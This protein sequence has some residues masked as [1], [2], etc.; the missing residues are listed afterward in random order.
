[1]WWREN[2]RAKLRLC[3]RVP[4]E[5]FLQGHLLTG[6]LQRE[7][8]SLPVP[9]HLAVKPPAQF[10]C[11]WSLGP[12]YGN[13]RFVALVI[14]VV[15]VLGIVIL[16]D[17][18]G[19]P[20]YAQTADSSLDYPENSTAAVAAFNA[21]DQDGDEIRW[22]LSGR[23]HALFIIDGGVLAFRES[24]NYEEPRSAIN[25]GQLSERNVY[26]VT[27]E[28]NGGTHDVVVT[29]TDVDDA[30]TASIDR[31]Q[32]QVS[33][34]LGAGLSDEDVGVS[35]QR[36]QWSRSENR[37]TWT[38]IEG[39]TSPRWSPTESDEG[40]YLRATVTYSDKFGSGKTA[41][42]VSAR[43]V[44]ART[45][46]NAA[47]SFVDRRGNEVTLVTLSVRENTAVGR[48]IGRRIPATDAD[49]DILFYELLDT[50]DLEDDD[51]DAR[52][53]IDSLSGQ[54]KVGKVLGADDGE[55]EDEATTLT[56][57]PALPENED[58]DDAGNSEYVLRVKVSDPS[59]A[60]ATVNVIV[61]VTNV[62]EPP[63]FIE[64]VPTLLR[65]KE[66]E[67]PPVITFGDNDSPVDAD[68]FAVTDQDGG[69]VTVRHRITGDDHE[70]LE[71]D[72]RVLT[73]KADHEPDFEMQ[74][75]YSI[76]ITA[77]S[78]G[79][80]VSLDVT[81]EVVDGEDLGEVSLSQR[82]PQVGIEVHATPSDPDGGMRIRRWEWERSDAITVDEDGNPSAECREDPDMPLNVVDPNSWTT[83]DEASTAAYTPE[84]ADVDRCLRAT[85]FYTDNFGDREERATEVFEA[86]VQSR[87]TANAAPT[88]VDQDLNSPGDQSVRT[89]RKIAEN[90]EAGQS[91]GSP[92]AAFDDDD[93]L[94]IYA[95][96]G[97]DAAFFSLSRND[98]QLKTKASLNFEAR[99]SYAVVVTAT[100]PSGASDSIQVTINVT[101][102][103]DPVHITG[104][105]SVS[106]VENGTDPV[107]SFTAF[108]EGEHVIRW[109][110]SGRDDGVFTI[111]DGVLAFKEPPNYEDPQSAST[112]AV[113]SSRNEYRVTVEAAGGTRNVTVTVTDVDEVGSV[114]ID[115]PQPQVGRLLSASLLDEDDGVEE[116]M[117]RWARSEDRRR[118][119]HIEGATSP[120]RLPA[121]ADEGMYLR[122][123]VTYTD[124]FGSGKT[125]RTVT[126]NPV[127]ARPPA[128]A[129]PSFSDQDD[130]EATRY[131]DV[132]RFVDEGNVKRMAIGEP[133]SA[134]DADEDILFYEFLDTPDL[135]DD[136][137]DARFTID[138]LS[139]QI[140]VGKV[141]GADPGE[142]EDEDS[143]TL[144]G[145]PALPTDE[146]AG[147]AGNSE[148]VLRVRASDP[149]TAT[150]I[151]NVIV[152]VT[153][154]NEAPAFGEDPPTL[155]SVVENVDP[156]V[157]RIGHGS[158]SI[159]AN[160][161][162][163]TDQ[164][165][166]VT[167]PDGYDDTTYAYSVSGAD[168][169]AF[170]FDD[171][172]VLGFSTGHSPD[173]EDQSSYSISIVAHSG[174][175]SRTLSTTLDVTVE[176]VDAEDAGAVF[177][178][179]RQP[180]VGVAVHATASDEDG[181]VTIRRWA[182]ERSDVVTVDDR[183]VPSHECEDNP[184]TPGIDVVGGWTAIAG[185]SSAVYAPQSAD[186][187]RC[188][189]ARVLYIDNVGRTQDEA[190]GVLE[191]PVGRHGSF[192]TDPVSDTG[193]VNAP[194]VFP[195][196]DFAT[197]GDQSDRTIR[198]VAENTEQGRSIGAAV[199]ALDEDDDL[200]I[201]T[202]SG[203]DAESFRIGR[204][205]GQ[206]KT[207]APLNFEAKSSYSVVVTA[208]DP[209]GA[210]DSIQVTINVTDED[211]PP[212]ITVLEE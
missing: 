125:A 25:G 46:S 79:R 189:R 77:T 123:T 159:D 22:S 115:R 104:V 21:Y 197:E 28:A 174:E 47:P 53:N 61:R 211:D 20:A 16:S 180:E 204:N 158:S 186:V 57:V 55:R 168:G 208:T 8:G 75:S 108:D 119:T 27:V 120:Q 163:V 176:V 173:F 36:W 142:I 170:A 117:W 212:V 140:R 200:L 100:D 154:V 9:K 133:V 179:Q 201:Y 13:S 33:R 209:F 172:G 23:D 14:A 83:I 144:I 193:F 76:T 178:S 175:G 182:W 56:G 135:D 84:P 34:P 146:D 138:S 151:V 148:Y 24:P 80:S 44:E 50:P 98:G 15:A 147:D 149:S 7:A 1:M 81:I 70:V 101:D 54:I 99:N 65:V 35:G 45:L 205:D 118:W 114:S 10:V 113:L 32:P 143:T 199:R 132:A 92:V 105:S 64:N 109:S 177:L 155:L 156:P 164:D 96:S 95:L 112:S 31:P 160:T 124:K 194:P 111:D 60:S 73:F 67:D 66:N 150:A 110:V 71:F 129:A 58:A 39:A 51:G 5:P 127:E 42:A 130:D 4:F 188:L 19:H 106:Y 134:T 196:Q 52:F 137:G 74:S 203:P 59:T 103:H 162:A 191:V 128:N 187:S 38:D 152:R 185:V 48:P 126:A 29:V 87:R 37:T 167:G 63:A 78:G 11:H 88:F 91:I 26:R 90:T 89:S 184:D 68:T 190:V 121:A 97:A 40:M 107:A 153:E 136:D 169:D 161:Y 93:N 165:G 198:E 49:A 145:V 166:S 86:P 72:S 141:L 202:M 210:T 122:A 2:C 85:V 12:L 94:L 192:D 195:D 62:N 43:R 69:N 131:I 3:R 17:P 18:L 6:A 30:G 116:Q 41:L 183:G 157:I 102:V 171:N 207:E 206:L 181:G 139:G 82:Q